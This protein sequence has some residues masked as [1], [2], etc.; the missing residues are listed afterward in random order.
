[1]PK[2]FEVPFLIAR[3]PEGQVAVADEQEQFEP[4]WINPAQALRLGERGEFSMIFPTIRT[5]ERLKA[6]D[7]VDAV[8]Q[9]CDSGQPLWTSC[10]RAGFMNGAEARYMEGE[11]PYGEL[12]LVS[13]DG[14][15]VHELQWQHEQ[16]VQL[17]K[18]LQRLTAPNPS[19]MT[20]PGT[21]TYIVGTAQTGFVVI[22][23]GPGVAAHAQRLADITGGNIRAIVCTHSHADHWPAG[24]LLQSILKERGQAV[25]PL[26]GVQSGE[27]AR[28]SAQFKPDQL[29]SIAELKSA[30]SC[31][32]AAGNADFSYELTPIATPGHASNHLCFVLEEDALLISG[33]HIL[34]GS[35]TV[36]DPPDGNMTD[37]LN[38]LDVLH[39]LCVEKGIQHILPAHG[40]VLGSS[41]LPASHHIAHLKAH[42]LKREAKIAA[43]MKALPD[44]SLE[45]LLPKAYDDVDA[46]LWPVA[47]RSLAAHVARLRAMAA[48]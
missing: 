26:L 37:Y 17:L 46:R 4:T 35:T 12:E 9:A 31:W 28:A 30:I 1:M 27:H 22:D 8:L 6:F 15:I 19:M 24:P 16:P 36:I 20:G 40:W 23:P 32:A 2:R 13:P 47:A 48:E 38:S 7:T 45:A 10:P 29:L 3:M 18:H 21:N 42:R 11:M 39:A 41:A 25:P 33:D 43:A 14:Q 5:L 44:A 34:N